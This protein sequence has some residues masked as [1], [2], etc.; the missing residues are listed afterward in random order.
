[1]LDRVRKVFKC[2]FLLTVFPFAQAQQQLPDFRHPLSVKLSIVT[3]SLHKPLFRHNGGFLVH[4]KITN[5][6]GQDQAITVWEPGGGCWISDNTV[7]S[8]EVNTL[9]TDKPIKILLKPGEVHTEDNEVF[10]YSR[11]Q[12]AITFKLG[13]FPAANGHVSCKRDTIPRDQISRSNAVTLTQ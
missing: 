6:S 10:W 7:I 4:A 5:I 11:T 8:T 13:F 2:L 9:S 12:P 1:M 3:D